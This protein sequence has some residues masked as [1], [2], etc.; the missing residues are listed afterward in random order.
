MLHRFLG[1][2]DEE[3]PDPG[4]GSAAFE[5]SFMDPDNG[6]YRPPRPRVT[7]VLE[8]ADRGRNRDEGQ[9]VPDAITSN[10]VQLSDFLDPHL[11]TAS[12][13]DRPTR[14]WSVRK[15]AAFIIGVSLVLWGIIFEIIHYVHRFVS[16]RTKQ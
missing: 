10:I 16:S 3:M 12:H 1:L 7:S 6:E 2:T 8:V 14:R 15:A 11:P 4:A 9:D 5:S 13:P